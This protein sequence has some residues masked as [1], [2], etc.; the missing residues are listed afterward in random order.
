[1]GLTNY[2]RGGA[3]VNNSKIIHAVGEGYMVMLMYFV[4]KTVELVD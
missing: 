2:L 1:L 3:S 4:S